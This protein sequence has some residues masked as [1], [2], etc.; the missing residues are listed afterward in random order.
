MEIGG[1]PVCSSSIFLS[2]P[3]H[4]ESPGEEKCE[5][6]HWMHTDKWPSTPHVER[7]GTPS[8]GGL[9]GSV[10]PSFYFYS[11]AVETF[12]IK[13]RLL[14]LKN[15][16]WRKQ[17]KDLAFVAL[18]QHLFSRRGEAHTHTHNY[19]FLI[20]IVYVKSFCWH[21]CWSSPCCR[22]CDLSAG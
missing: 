5:C 11:A 21:I 2:S 14:K 1:R 12:S 8:R 6:E 3:P 18:T 16:R 10:S 20:Y 17:I 9:G 19:M 7:K 4:L 22:R 15:C 13:P